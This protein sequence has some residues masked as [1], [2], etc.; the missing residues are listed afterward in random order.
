MLGQPPVFGSELRRLRIDAG[1]TLTGMASLVHYSKGQLSKVETGHKRPS[2][3]LARLC[4]AALEA[5]G[6]LAALVHT[7]PSCSPKS[8]AAAGALDEA[9]PSGQL[10]GEVWSMSSESAGPDRSALLGRRRMVAAGAASVLSLGLTPPAA[11]AHPEG[12]PLLEAARNLFDHFR[13]LGQTAGPQV[14]LPAVAAQTRSLCEAA[15]EASPRARQGL[16]IVGARYAEYAGWMAQE[17]DDD[18]AALWWTDQA[19]GLAE[20]GGDRHLATYALVRRALITFYADDATETIAL[21]RHAQE[22]AP[23]PRIA[24]LAAQQE[25][26]GH[27]LAGDRAACLHALDRAREL[28]SRPAYDA[29]E[30]VIGT[31][32]LSDPVAMITG[33]CLHDLGRPRQAAEI[34]DREMAQIPANALRTQARY[35]VR[36]ALAHAAAGEIDHACALTRGLLGTVGLVRSA[37]ITTDLRR[38]ARTLTRYR[39]HRAVRDLSPDL[40]LALHR[41]AH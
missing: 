28:L 1:L 39:A 6:A 19:V 15:H 21:A 3:E 27:A 26:Q 41:P 7:A 35:G 5:G 25:A 31:Q 10:E 37:T 8:P 32:H 4:D 14:V 24:G 23:P 11:A 38:L 34:L 12:A 9:L 22:A 33:W 16:L 17:A 20:A 36:R 2:P 29:S 13:T 18:T 30:P 40:T